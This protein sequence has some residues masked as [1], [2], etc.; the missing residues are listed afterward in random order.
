MVRSLGMPILCPRRIIS[1]QIKYPD[2]QYEY[3][4]KKIWQ[5]PKYWNNLDATK[6]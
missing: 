4:K 6:L 2:A 5:L 1:V 3:D